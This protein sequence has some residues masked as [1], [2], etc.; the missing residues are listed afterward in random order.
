MEVR[1]DVESLFVLNRLQYG[2]FFPDNTIILDTASHGRVTVPLSTTNSVTCELRAQVVQQ[3]LDTSKNVHELE[4]FTVVRAHEVMAN[5]DKQLDSLLVQPD[6]APLLAKAARVWLGHQLKI[7]VHHD[8]PRGDVYGLTCP[9]FLGSIARDR[10]G[11]VGIALTDQESIVWGRFQLR[12]G[13]IR[14][15]QFRRGT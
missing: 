10:N 9:Q 1:K 5:R 4:P 2:D 14:R 15:D 3:I 11:L 12:D 7:F 13:A 8:V 6:F